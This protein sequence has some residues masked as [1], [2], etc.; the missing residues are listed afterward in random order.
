[1]LSAIFGAKPESH[2]LSQQL[3]DLLGQRIALSESPVVQVPAGKLLLPAGQTIRRLPL[4]L[5]GR[6]DCVLPMDQGETSS[7]VP[8]SFGAGEVAMLSQ[9]FC[10]RPVWVDVVAAQDCALRWLDVKDIEALM[11]QVP[12]LLLLLAKFLSQRLREVQ[13]RERSWVERGVRN[14]VRAHLLRMAQKGTANAQGQRHILATHEE[15]AARCGISRPKVSLELKRLE[16]QGWIRL[17]RGCIEI[18][19]LDAWLRE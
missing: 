19:D 9:V 6:V 7:I 1:M 5:K 3:G 16:Q 18:L 17:R 13:T 10:N 12:E 11:K 4:L 2:E 15:V 14:R 8:V